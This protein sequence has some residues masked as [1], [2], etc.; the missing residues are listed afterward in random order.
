MNLSPSA[1]A[2]L[3]M[4]SHFGKASTDG[5][6]PLSI[7]EWGRFA[8]WLK[9]Q[10]ATPEDLL[11]PSVGQLLEKWRDKKF[12][13]ARITQLLS[14]GHAL[15][16]AVEKWQRAGLCHFRILPK[17][18]APVFDLGPSLVQSNPGLHL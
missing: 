11:R 4:T 3:L 16:L 14:R 9:D 1:Q 7:V 2:T 15:A 12:D 10:A 13:A 5:P 17:D 18:W 8:L 6:R